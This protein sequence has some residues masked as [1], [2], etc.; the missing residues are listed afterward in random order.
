[1]K[2]SFHESL[3][4]LAKHIKDFGEYVVVHI[5]GW[6]A[7]GKTLLTQKLKE[8]LGDE[9]CHS[10][11]MDDYY[12]GRVFIREQESLG[13]ICSF[14]HEESFDIPLLSQHI[15][16]L[17][18]NREIKKPIYSM[19]SEATTWYEVVFPKKI[20]IIEWLYALHTDIVH[21]ADITIFID[22]ETEIRKN[23]RIQRDS[24]RTLQSQDEIHEM[25]ELAEKMYIESIRPTLKNA[26][27]IIEN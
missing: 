18:K 13:N 2:Y 20:I 16:E 8:H 22:S 21:H 15:W 6:T 1:M 12:K 24:Q 26:H 17:K 10:I 25:F 3:D 23:R 4:H 27:I 14:D 11:E 19:K 5:A 7:S 9:E